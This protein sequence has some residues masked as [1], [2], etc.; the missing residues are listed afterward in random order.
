MSVMHENE[1][2]FKLIDRFEGFELVELLNI[3]IE[4]VVEHFMDTI[5]NNR[6]FLEDY[7]NHGR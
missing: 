7:L 6:E 3:S 1:F 5:E 4:D 2:L